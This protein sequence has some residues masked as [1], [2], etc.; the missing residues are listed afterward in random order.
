LRTNQKYDLLSGVAILVQFCI[1]KLSLWYFK[2]ISDNRITL[3]RKQGIGDAIF[4]TGVLETFIERYPDTKVTFVT[5]H[6]EVFGRSTETDFSIFSFPMVW[7]M[8]EHWDFN[9]LKR[10]DQHIKHII[11]SFLG[12]GLPVK[13]YS[14]PQAGNSILA[15]LGIKEGQYIVIHPWAGSWNNKRNWDVEKWNYLVDGLANKMI[16]Q[17]GSNKDLL[18]GGVIDLRGKTTV[19]E[20][21]TIIE[22]AEFFIGVN[23]FAEQ[24]AATYRV[25]SI[26]LYGATHPIYS[27][28]ENQVAII[29]NDC[30]RLDDLVNANFKF[31]KLSNIEVDKVLL[32]YENFDHQLAL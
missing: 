11:S 18:I 32:A 29:G 20:S 5:N 12:L 21:F 14:L 6:P 2:N 22:N 19:Q 30:Y 4:V 27:L 1:S 31:Q 25:P 13:P 9:L 10:K 17:I 15:E 26:I 7:L 16:C 3:I 23:S 24:V 28:N 8:Y